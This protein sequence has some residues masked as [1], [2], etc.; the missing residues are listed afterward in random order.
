MNNLPCNLF[1]SGYDFGIA[2]LLIFV[3]F[4]QKEENIK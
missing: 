4:Q 1:A 2:V 3:H